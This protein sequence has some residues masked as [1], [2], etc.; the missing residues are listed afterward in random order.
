MEHVPGQKKGDVVL[1]ALSTCGWCAKTKNLLNTLGVEYWFE[2]VDLLE[3]DEKE[4]ALATVTKW[5]PDCSFPTIVINDK[6]CIIGFKEDKIR[7]ALK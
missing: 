5:N 2:Y 3:D 7:E 4:K 1:Y 6:K